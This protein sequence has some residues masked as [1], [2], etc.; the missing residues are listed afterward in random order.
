MRIILL[1]ILIGF[2]SACAAMQ[3]AKVKKQQEEL[4]ECVSLGFKPNT[5]AFGNCRLQLR[6][7]E[8]QRFQAF[9]GRKY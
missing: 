6:N 7:I 5:P 9:F 8:M 3:E 4:T 2:L 1:I